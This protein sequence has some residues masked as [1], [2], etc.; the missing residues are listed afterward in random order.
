[1]SV[2]L[3]ESHLTRQGHT[4]HA[5]YVAPLHL[6]LR[7]YQRTLRYAPCVRSMLMPKV[8]RL[9]RNGFAHSD[10]VNNN[11]TALVPNGGGEDA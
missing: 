7:R 3:S 2:K 5:R 4:N 10:I 9:V 1:M 8:C 6:I 11:L